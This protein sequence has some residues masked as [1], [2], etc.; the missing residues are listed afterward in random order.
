M[1]YGSIVSPYIFNQMFCNETEKFDITKESRLFVN[2][3]FKMV[4][5]IIMT[6]GH[7]YI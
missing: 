6:R 4:F 2:I 3:I 5:G 7:H 1:L